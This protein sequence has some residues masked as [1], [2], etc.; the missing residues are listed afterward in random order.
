MN[1]NILTYCIYGGITIYIIV[2]V[3]RLFHTNGRIFILRLFHQNESV[4]DTTNNLLLLAY[5][6]FNIGYAVV[7]FSLWEKITGTD[8]LIASVAEKTGILI[9]I[10]AITHYFN[11][12]LIYFLSK[13]NSFITSKNY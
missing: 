12:A 7:Q 8:M 10:L 3:G 2:W 1:Y 4:T 6:L 9:F 5:Y 11:I 13:K